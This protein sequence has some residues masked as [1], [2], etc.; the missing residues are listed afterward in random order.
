MHEVTLGKTHDDKFGLLIKLNLNVIKLLN[1]TSKE[2]IE[3]N[4]ALDKLIHWKVRLAFL[5][6]ANSSALG[7]TGNQLTKDA[8]L[9]G[10]SP[11]LT[12][13]N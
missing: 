13:E 1:T 8:W 5:S 4:V 11:I 6:T 2:S 10:S 9:L 12:L 3:S 7:L